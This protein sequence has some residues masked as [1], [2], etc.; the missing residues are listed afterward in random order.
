MSTKLFHHRLTA[1]PPS[2][3][4][5]IPSDILNRKLPPLPITK[6]N[7]PVLP[8]LLPQS[9]THTT[10][11][12]KCIAQKH[13][14]TVLSP[15]ITITPPKDTISV[16]TTFQ[17]LFKKIGVSKAPNHQIPST[18][19]PIH[20]K[21]K[22]RPS[23]QF[24]MHDT[25]LLNAL[26]ALMTKRYNEENILFLQ[27]VNQLTHH[28]NALLLTDSE[29]N[30]V[31]KDKI[32]VE[33]TSIYSTYIINT[34]QK[35]INLSGECFNEIMYIH[36]RYTSLPLTKSAL[37]FERSVM[38]ITN[39]IQTSILSG[40]YAANA[41]QSIAADRNIY[42]NNVHVSEDSDDIEY[43][44]DSPYFDCHSATERNKWMISS[45][46]FAPRSGIHEWEI[47]ILKTNGTRQ[48]FGVVSAFDPRMVVNE[49]G[50]CDTP[51]LGARAVYGY[52][53]MNPTFYYAAY[54]DDN[55]VRIN[56]DLS[57]LAVHNNRQWCE[58]DVIRICLNQSKGWIKFYLNQ[59]Q[60]RKTISIEKNR[61]YYPIILY[62]GACKF[63]V[64]R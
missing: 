13:N 59:K 41:F 3:L 28:I 40:F 61:T 26:I 60:V 31:Q 18:T 62:S 43:S 63:H 22:W 1:P 49:F 58:G 56:K 36:Q 17:N 47:K 19:P 5:A 42:T 25:E 45:A 50:I 54:N 24:I 35:Q 29:P 14:K 32:D 34:A 39:L 6:R 55:K 44:N 46:G 48:E 2:N 64:Q 4:N 15:C 9:H 12:N 27:S 8:V 21:S 52:N 51:L 11:R 10:R 23:L 20:M 33:I 7:L 37:I 57:S 30:I 16:H 38:E 53:E